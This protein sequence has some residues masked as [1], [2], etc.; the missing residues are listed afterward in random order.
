MSMNVRCLIKFVPTG[1][2]VLSVR[3]SILKT[4]RL[5]ESCEVSGQSGAILAH[6]DICVR[7]ERPTQKDQSPLAKAAEKGN[8]AV[9]KLLFE[10]GVD[11]K[12][13]DE[14]S[15]TALSQAAENGYEAVVRLLLEKGADPNGMAV[16]EM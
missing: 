1:T 7:R 8:Q 11:P 6:L 15:W 16:T 10:K 14:D 13:E 12:F 2:R 9:M 4:L 3:H 5:K